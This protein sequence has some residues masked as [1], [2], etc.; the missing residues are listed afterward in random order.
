MFVIRSLLRIGC[1]AFENLPEIQFFLLNKALP[2]NAHC[3]T[4]SMYDS[5]TITSFVIHHCSLLQTLCL[6]SQSF[7]YLTTFEVSDC[8]NLVTISIGAECCTKNSIACK[9]INLSKVSVI[10]FGHSSF[11]QA[12]CLQI[13]S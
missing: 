3:Y 6:S 7:P 1:P 5:K 2:N 13:Q 11:T 12:T 4:T 9:F 10:T 8:T